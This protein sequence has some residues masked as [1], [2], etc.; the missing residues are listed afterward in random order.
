LI[1]IYIFFT[2]PGKQPG[3]KMMTFEGPNPDRKAIEK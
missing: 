2:L 3:E 1:S